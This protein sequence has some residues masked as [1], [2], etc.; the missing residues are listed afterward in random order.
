M[1]RD[2]IISAVIEKRRDRDFCADGADEAIKWLESFPVEATEVDII[3]ALDNPEWA[4]FWA[5][6]VG[7]HRDQLAEVVLKA[8]DAEWAYFW[9]KDV[10]THRDQ[11]A[12]IVIQ[13]GDA[14]WTDFWAEI[15]G[16]Y[17]RQEKNEIGNQD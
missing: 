3:A 14:K 11:M 7:T 9:A 13:A 4:Y 16:T 17:K 1:T 2:K 15:I 8:G 12:E 5:R 10:G 6:D